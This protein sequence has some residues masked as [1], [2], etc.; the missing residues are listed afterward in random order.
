MPNKK[1]F[2]IAGE[3]SGDTH[4]SNLIKELKKSNPTLEIHG[5]G[6][7]QMKEAGCNL[8]FNMMDISVIGFIE[9]LKHIRI[10]KKIFYETLN[11]ILKNNFDEVV[12]I[13]YPGFNLRLLSKI[14]KYNKNI[15]L[16]YYISPQLWAWH[17]SRVEI[18]KKCADKM[19][20]IF[21]FEVEFYKKHGYDN[22]VFCGHPLM[23][24]K[25]FA[26]E[27][28]EV[29]D[30]RLIGLFPGSRVSEIKSNLPCMLK[31][32]MLLKQKGNYEFCIASANNKCKAVIEKII[33][34]ESAE[35]VKLTTDAYDLMRKAKLV[36][37]ASGT[38]TVEIACMNTPM[39]IV[40]KVSFLT[41]VIAKFLV[42]VDH[43]G[44]VNIIGGSRIVPELVQ[45][46]FI[47]EKVV[48]HIEDMINNKEKYAQVKEKLNFVKNKLGM[49][50]ASYK[51]AQEILSY[52]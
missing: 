3:K 32:A 27:N 38:A 25:E 1:I 42:K 29:R 28:N 4:A 7:P 21:P 17:T 23:D 12:F 43:I 20:V 24:S 11:F 51:A 50:G 33:K 41:W 39:I 19:L 13:D 26:Q 22:V 34:L 36:V 40:Y 37:T 44:M 31:S 30:E 48:S 15:K 6:G 10:Y 18:I 9:V 8:F 35:F 16:I 46:D 52:V 2:I 49:K 5:L 45:Y 14:R 47:P